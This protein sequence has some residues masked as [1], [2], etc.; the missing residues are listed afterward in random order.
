M[1]DKGFLQSD[2]P[3]AF[4]HRGGIQEFPEN[5]LKAF[6]GAFDLGF[7][8]METDVHATKDGELVAFH[9]DRL[10]RVTNRKGK[11]AQFNFSD[12]S[13]A[14]IGGSEPIP[15]LV[16][17]LEELP[18]AKFNID[19]KHDAAV[20]PLAEIV[21]RTNSINRV[22]IGSFSDN[23]IK[24]VAKLVGPKLCTGMGPKSI[25]RL[26]IS[27]IAN[28]FLDSPFGDCAQV[29]SKI[30]GVPFITKEFVK[31]AHQS[32]KVVHAWTIN[33]SEEIEHLLDLG[34]DGI[35]TD[36]LS[37]LKS[38]YLARGIWNEEN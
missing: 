2:F 4:A 18:D 23:R 36:N 1:P 35:M 27:K 13:S 12:L 8:Y 30:K 34:V 32:G 37:T 31:R 28:L 10:D 29:P 19:P 21:K 15:L 7:R 24:R 14:L 26:Q 33:E 20:E 22:C 5:S 11:I 17:L 25:S 3:I 38:V 9:D 6:K 16:D